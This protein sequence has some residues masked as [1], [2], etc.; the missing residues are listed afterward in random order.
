M[1]ILVLA[2]SPVAGRVKTRLCPPLTGQQAAEVAEAALHDTLVAA[3][4][5]GADERVLALDGPPGPWLPSRWRVMAQAGAAFAERLHH[6]WADGTGPTLQIGMDTPQVTTALLDHAMERLAA[7]D[8]VIGPADDGG[9]WALG[10]QEP[11]P[12]VFDGVPMSVPT[13]YARQTT[14]LRE[15]ALHPEQLDRLVDV[16]TWTDALAVAAIATGGRYAGVVDRLHRDV[17]VAAGPEPSL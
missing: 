8:C 17:A 9:W 5:S 12:G 11:R 15:L 4:A 1:R 7:R 16:D 6:A 3:G 13:T 2:K 14:R 10:L